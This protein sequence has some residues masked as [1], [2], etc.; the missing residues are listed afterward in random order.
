MEKNSIESDPF[1]VFKKNLHESKRPLLCASF[2]KTK[3]HSIELDC[4]DLQSK[5]KHNLDAIIFIEGNFA[6]GD[7]DRTYPT[8]LK[9]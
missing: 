9:Y 8:T 3:N 5:I 6:P 7:I 2:E 1:S 4:A